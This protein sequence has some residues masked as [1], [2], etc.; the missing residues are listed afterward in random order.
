[1][2]IVVAFPGPVVDRRRPIAAPTLIGELHMDDCMFIEHLETQTSRQVILLND[3]SAAA[4]FFAKHSVSPNGI[5][6]T[7]SSGI[8]SKIFDRNRARW[9]LDEHPHAGEIGH[10]T[11]DDAH[12]AP[13]CDC[14]QRGHLGAIAS[15]RAAERLARH[16]ALLDSTAFASSLC[17][18][19]FDASAQSIEN[20]R[21]L[22]PAVL[23]GDAWA[24]NVVDA[25][26]APLARALATIAAANGLTS[27]VVMGGFALALGDTYIE[28]LQTRI[29]TLTTGMLARSLDV[30]SAFSYAQTWPALRGCGIFARITSLQ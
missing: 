19:K 21:H 24:C 20:E 26:I 11:V 30:S 12:D 9:V 22:V 2:P 23:A 29:D 14:G 17:R 25:G 1:M 16:R 5:V 18:I 8:G 15:G 7:V 10:V 27:V 4:W 13:T 28:R 6:V 3:V